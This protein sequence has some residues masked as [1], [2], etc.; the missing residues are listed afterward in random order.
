MLTGLFLFALFAAF[1]RPFVWINRKM[2]RL[3]QIDLFRFF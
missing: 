2:K 3:P 1:F